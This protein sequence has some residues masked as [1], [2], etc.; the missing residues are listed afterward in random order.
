LAECGNT[1]G[2][3]L[4]KRWYEVNM[5]KSMRIVADVYLRGDIE[6]DYLKEVAIFTKSLS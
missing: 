5:K 6:N 2:V 4:K 1:E 3:D